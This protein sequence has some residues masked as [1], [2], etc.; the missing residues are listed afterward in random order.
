[1][2][3]VLIERHIADDLGHHYDKAA[4]ETMQM[5]MQA[6][7]YISGEALQNAYDPN[8]RL[9]VA[10]YRTLQD[11]QRWH[12]SSERLEMMA[13]INPMLETE[14]KITVFEH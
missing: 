13:T 3:R 4:R 12:S 1:M 11:W 2:I 14:E 7:G 10:T 8:H 6:H 9:V 5:A